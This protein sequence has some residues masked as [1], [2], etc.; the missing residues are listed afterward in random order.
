MG[1][2]QY[3]YLISFCC[4]CFAE[5]RS[6]SSLFL[7]V[8][9]KY[10][11]LWHQMYF[12]NPTL[13]YSNLALFLF[14]TITITVRIISMS[15]S[16]TTCVTF[17]SWDRNL[18]KISQ[19]LLIWQFMIINSWCRI[20]WIIAIMIH[21][22]QTSRKIARNTICYHAYWYSDVEKYGTDNIWIYL[23]KMAR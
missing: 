8:S 10:C 2:N 3:R 12:A 4:C 23:S 17:T 22:Y 15:P 18:R 7:N 11:L 9:R 13:F 19:Q 16:N 21:C 20:F 6:L 5:L 1:C 14:W